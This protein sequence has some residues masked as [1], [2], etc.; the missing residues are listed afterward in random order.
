M[1]NSTIEPAST[2]ARLRTA[3]ALL[4][5]LLLSAA[6]A[7]FD[8]HDETA[9]DETDSV[10]SPPDQPDSF[11]IV[12]L[13]ALR[14]AEDP[15]REDDDEDVHEE[16]EH[17]W[18]RI[19]RRFA[20][21]DCPGDS[22]ADRWARWYS[23]RDEYMDRVLTRA[24]PWLHDIANEL[25]ARDL[26][27]ELA[28]LP[29]VE[30]AYDP[31]AYS[32]GRASGTW[33]FL[34]AT[35]RDH[36]LTINDYYDG[37]RDVWAATRAALDYLAYLHDR[38]DDWNLALAAYNAGQGRVQR[39][40]NRNRS[41]G[42]GTD[43]QSLTLPRETRAYIPKINGLGCLFANPSDYGFELPVWD[44]RPR[45]ARVDI[46]SAVDVVALAAEAELDIAELIALNPGLNRHLTPPSGPHH[47]IVPV[48]QVETV[49]EVLPDI[50]T[51]D[52]LVWEEVTV[53]NGDTLSHIAHRYNTSVAELRR[54]NDL[55]GDF[56]RAGQTLRIAANGQTPEDSP[57]ADLYHELARLQRR[58][59]PTKRFQH[60]VRPGENLWLI[61]R[62]YRVS[63][64]DLRRWNNLGSDNLIRP[65][66]RLMVHMEQA[67]GQSAAAAVEYTIRSGDSLWVI[68]RRHGVSVRD[69]MRWNNLHEDSVLRPGQSLTI[70]R[71]GS[72]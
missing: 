22:R 5:T 12:E 42:R 29:I 27:G 34:T 31:F 39:A 14:L 16:P 37:R 50:N 25:D 43:W 60:Q 51:E 65:G 66:Q 58:L 70:R 46:D 67:S 53:R 64:A 38:F 45:V 3:S 55:N 4:L 13:A 23:E 15:P 62:Q 1:P 35:A 21:A 52:M 32:H 8:R 49:R 24:R 20:F 71:S 47:L 11:D 33:Q 6:C 10:V 56:L 28:L 18:E 2:T 36:G 57:H 9:Q 30:S 63:I 59:L 41:N 19:V 44:D 48:D 26:P 72:G 69:L 17:L 54:A 68:A 61:A 7:T 40:V